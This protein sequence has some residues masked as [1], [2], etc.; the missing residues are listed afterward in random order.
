MTESFVFTVVDT[1]NISKSLYR[2]EE[3]LDEQDNIKY[4]DNNDNIK[5]INQNHVYKTVLK[6]NSGN[7]FV[8]YIVDSLKLDV[9]TVIKVETDIWLPILYKNNFTVLKKL[10]D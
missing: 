7:F 9:G 2:Q 5:K 4:T 3:L 10:I 1:L 6:N 8:V